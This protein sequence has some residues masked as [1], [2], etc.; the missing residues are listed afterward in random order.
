MAYLAVGDFKYGMD[1]RRPQTSGIPGTLWILKNAVLSRGGDIERTKKFA[2]RFDLPAGTVGMTTLKGQIYVFGSGTTPSGIPVGVQ[3]QQLIA[4]STPVMTRVVDVKPFDGKLYVIAEYADGNMYHFY[5]GVRITDWDALADASSSHAAVAEVLAEK[6]NGDDTIQATAFGNTVIIEAVDAGTPFTVSTGTADPNVASTPTA[7]V[8]LLQANVVEVAGVTATGTV[9]I[10]GGT[11]SPGVNRLASLT[12]DGVE[13][14]EGP[15]N[16]VSSNDATANAVV[17]AINN[18]SITH[19]YLA[20]AVGAVVTISAPAEEWAA[21]NGLVVSATV[22]GDVTATTANMA[23]GVTPVEPVA[24]ISSVVISG[25]SF[26]APDQ[27]TI[28]LNGVSRVTTGR[29]AGTGTSILIHKNRVWST[30]GSLFRYCKLNDPSNWSDVAASTGAGFINMASQAEGAQRLVGAAVYNEYVAIFARSV[31]IVYSLDQD[32]E[33]NQIIQIVDNTGTMAFRSI[34]SYGAN[35][36]FYLD[37]TGVRS[38]RSRDGYN[39]A[40]ASDVGSAIDPYA[41]EVMREVTGAELASASAVIEG[42]NGRYFLAIGNRIIILSYF[43]SS[44]I[45]AW[46]YIDFEQSIDVFIRSERDIFLRSGNTIYQYGGRS[47]QEYPA[48]EE[49]PV[50]AETPFASAQDPANQKV[51]QG[52]DH[53]AINTWKVEVLVDPNDTSKVIDAGI[54]RGT[55]YHKNSNKMP[56]YAPIFAM[57]YTCDQAGF[58]SL[59]STAVHYENGERG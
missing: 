37:D 24:Q 22:A 20:S 25:G 44:K 51:L 5:D 7:A 34:V 42:L 3:Y 21:A 31:V 48:R 15:V 1:R 14:L 58:A 38:L 52:Y 47:G 41:Q 35:D 11:S 39:A 55:T 16:W 13:L 57:R 54:L 23:G 18:A 12:V 28:T 10:T 56:G 19:G 6:L 36:V 46:S 8:T 27:W 26:D 59:S 45:S 43:P 53:A 50:L 9:Q 40:Y 33:L 29:A 49:F 4:P 17:V 2:D 30:A 32:A